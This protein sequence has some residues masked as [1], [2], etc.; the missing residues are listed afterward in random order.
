MLKLTRREGEELIFRVDD[1]VC[2]VFFAKTKGGYIRLA[3]DAPEAVSIV[4]AELE[5]LSL[6]QAT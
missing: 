2:R 4:R 1:L 6:H 3:I 5:G